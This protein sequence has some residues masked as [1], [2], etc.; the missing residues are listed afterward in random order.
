MANIEIVSSDQKHHSIGPE[1]ACVCGTLRHMIEDGATGM[2]AVPVPVDNTT[3]A[4]VFAY[5]A[6]PNDPKWKR[7]LAVAT[8][9]TLLNIVHAANYL[10]VEPL[11]DMAINAIGATM[12]G[13]SAQDIRIMWNV[14]N[15]FTAVETDAMLE[16]GAWS[17]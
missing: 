9:T 10:D 4:C 17:Q 14:P 13:K 11:L 5:C 8:P 7:R 6:L 3:L 12:A 16:E 2:G 15:D 1:V